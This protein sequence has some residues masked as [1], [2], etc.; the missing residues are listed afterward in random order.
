MSHFERLSR[1][2]PKLVAEVVKTFDAAD[3]YQETYVFEHAT[4]TLDEFRYG[5]MSK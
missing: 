2:V 1:T 3:P 4:E 5:K